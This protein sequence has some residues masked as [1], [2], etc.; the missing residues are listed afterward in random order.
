MLK[1]FSKHN[2]E[3]VLHVI[4]DVNQVDE[5]RQDLTSPDQLLQ[6]SIIRLVN[7]KQVGPHAHE[8]RTTHM[9]IPVRTQEC[10]FVFRGCIEVQLFDEDQGFMG[11]Y[12]LHAGQLLIT[13]A[14]G[15]ALNCVKA[16]TVLLEFKNGPYLGRDYQ[17]FSFEQSVSCKSSS[18]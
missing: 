2:S 6:A 5:V 13:F 3:A 18:V 17:T 14:G 11:K 10:W 15:H 1:F 7:G 16:D 9:T 8:L 4:A 12:E